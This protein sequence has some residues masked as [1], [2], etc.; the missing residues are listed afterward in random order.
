MQYA[1]TPTLFS[2]EKGY[3]KGFSPSQ[4]ASSPLMISSPLFHPEN[5][6][7]LEEEE[8]KVFWSFLPLRK[9]G[10]RQLSTTKGL[11]GCIDR[12]VVFVLHLVFFRDF[13]KNCR[14]FTRGELK[15]PQFATQQGVGRLA[16]EERV[17]SSLGVCSL[18]SFLDGLFLLLRP[19]A[20][21]MMMQPHL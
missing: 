14:K 11:W 17:F 7:G 8:E 4:P 3:S 6:K 18:L 1:L 9:R 20:A 2:Q 15:K 19:L 10:K 13:F 5:D 21:V 16:R 12:H